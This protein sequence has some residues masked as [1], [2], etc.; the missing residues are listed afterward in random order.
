M[1]SCVFIV[2]VCVY[3]LAL[4]NSSLF[5][6][7]TCLFSKDRKKGCG[8]RQLGRVERLWE[9]LG[10]GERDETLLYNFFPLKMVVEENQF[11]EIAD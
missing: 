5:C 2:F 10:E 6:F 3:F 1:I 9:A 4:K 8:V 11:R 7:P